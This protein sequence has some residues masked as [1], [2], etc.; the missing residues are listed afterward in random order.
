MFGA[1]GAEKIREGR[2]A[3]DKASQETENHTYHNDDADERV[4]SSPSFKTINT[5]LDTFL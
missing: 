4:F 1:Q 5:L 3:G 2:D